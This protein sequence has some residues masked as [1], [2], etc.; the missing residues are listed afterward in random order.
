GGTDIRRFQQP[1]R[2]IGSLA[3][4]KIPEVEQEKVKPGMEKEGMLQNVGL[5]KRIPVADNDRSTRL[6]RNLLFLGIPARR[7]GG[8]RNKPPFQKQPVR[9]CER[10]RLILEAVTPWMI[11]RGNCWRM[12]SQE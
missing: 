9:R 12:H 5:V 8:G 6:A 3:F 7:G 1:G 4:A 2:R 10:Y 11:F